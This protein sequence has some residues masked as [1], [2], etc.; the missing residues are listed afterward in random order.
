VMSFKSRLKNLF[1]RPTNE[2]AKEGI[3]AFRTITTLL[4]KIQHRSSIPIDDDL[5]PKSEPERQELSRLNALATV[6]VMSNEIIAAV[7]SRQ[8]ENGG[9][10]VLAYQQSKNERTTTPSS[11][12]HFFINKNP[13]KDTVVSNTVLVLSNPNNPR[14]S[15]D[16]SDPAAQQ[17]L[18]GYVRKRWWVLCY[19]VSAIPDI[20]L[21][22]AG[23]R[24]RRTYGIS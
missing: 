3:L 14:A 13:R 24:W 4:A 6:I 8:P 2:D 5:R 23:K 1:P 11:L 22:G 16:D 7:A 17:K 12:F 10:G 15:W 20:I 21:I 9:L 18:I 19:N